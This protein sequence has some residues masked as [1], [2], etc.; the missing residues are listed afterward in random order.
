MYM[1]DSD[2]GISR[3]GVNAGHSLCQAVCCSG[4]CKLN[5]LNV[6]KYRKSFLC[7]VTTPSLLSTRVPYQVMCSRSICRTQCGGCVLNVVTSK[8]FL[9]ARIKSTNTHT[10]T[11]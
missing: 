2:P 6:L 5:M 9:K 11:G 10:R 8:S 1:Y 7:P 3:G 4:G